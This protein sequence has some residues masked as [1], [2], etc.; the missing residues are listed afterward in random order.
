MMVG[1]ALAC[2]LGSNTWLV[3]LSP[4]SRACSRRFK[5]DLVKIS[6]H[7]M[8]SRPQ[9]SS[10]VWGFKDFGHSCKRYTVWQYGSSASAVSLQNLRLSCPGVESQ[11]HLLT[12]TRLVNLTQ[13]CQLG[14][15]DLGSIVS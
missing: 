12:G 13:L 8:F 11:C 1:R 4:S 5:P 14:R 6:I 3:C 2:H 7:G 9:E 10:F 15:L